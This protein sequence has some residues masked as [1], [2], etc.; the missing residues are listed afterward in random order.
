MSGRCSTRGGLA[1]ARCPSL[2]RNRLITA[3]YSAVS[4]FVPSMSR[5]AVVAVPSAAISL[6]SGSFDGAA[7]PRTRRSAR[8]CVPKLAHGE[9]RAEL[10]TSL[11]EVLPSASLSVDYTQYGSHSSAVLAQRGT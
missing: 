8:R 3:G 2:S 1:R 4:A 9:Q 5:F 10:E 11:R 6:G 7:T